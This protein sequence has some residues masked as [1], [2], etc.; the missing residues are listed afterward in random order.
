MPW[1]PYTRLL[2]NATPR[3][4][5]ATK[6]RLAMPRAKRR[7]ECSSSRCHSDSVLSS[8]MRAKFICLSPCF[9]IVMYLLICYYFFGD[10][11]GQVIDMLLFKGMEELK[12][13]VD[14]SKQRH[15]LVGKYVIRNQEQVLML[16]ALR[17]KACLLRV[18]YHSYGKGLGEL[19]GDL[20]Q[21][22]KKMA[23]EGFCGYG[24]DDFLPSKG[25]AGLLLRELERGVHILVATPGRLVDLLE[26]AR[27]S[28]QMLRYLALDV[29]DRMLDMGFEYAI[30]KNDDA[31]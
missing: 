1:S 19:F 29:A 9:V 20:F 10:L 21:G 31:S 26:R 17:W 27:V 2:K 16:S 6:A 23:E 25:R 24:N 22:H 7:S 12:N 30:Y 28:L 13:C 3:L 8:N 14:H 15:R 4:L 11:A 18:V 5:V